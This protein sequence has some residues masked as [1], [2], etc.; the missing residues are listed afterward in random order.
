MTRFWLRV[1]LIGLAVVGGCYSGT[2]RPPTYPVSGTVMLKG[3]PLA[4]ATV[5]FVPAEGATQEPATGVTDA[6]GKFKLTTYAADDGAQLGDY[7][8]K[9]SKYDGK[10]ATK[11]EQDAYISYEEEQKIQFSADEKPTPPSKN[12]LSP[13]YANEATSG[14]TH[15]V[16]KGP[17][18]VELKLD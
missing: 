12:L 15:T 11:E 9:V 5:V 7:R 2:K 17:N 4:G 16:T 3:Q 10:K 14:F 1:P 13:K 18:T 6:A 8:I